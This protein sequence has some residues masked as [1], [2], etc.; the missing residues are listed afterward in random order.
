MNRII[1][2]DI[3]LDVQDRQIDK[4][5]DREKDRQ[6]VRQI[7]IQKEKWYSDGTPMVLQFQWYFNKDDFLDLFPDSSFKDVK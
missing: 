5:T 6:I 2:R 7:D 1:D 4:K 3:Q